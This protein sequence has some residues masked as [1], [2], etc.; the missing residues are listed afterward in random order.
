M[1]TQILQAL[2]GLVKQGGEMA[3]WGVAIY[4]VMQLLKILAIGGSI[5]ACIKTVTAAYQH[6]WDSKLSSK[7]SSVQLL[8]TEVQKHILDMLK[9]YN[10]SVST[11]LKDLGTQLKE[12]SE[13]LKKETK[14]T[15]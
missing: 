1:D 4:L 2:I 7:A 5:W 13:N 6:C 12:L 10:E 9:D 3:L 14:P 8:A 15:V 11:I